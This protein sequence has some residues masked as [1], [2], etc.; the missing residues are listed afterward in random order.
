[1]KT[2]TLLAALLAGAVLLQPKN[3]SPG[4]KPKPAPKP[5]PKPAPK[6]PA[7]LLLLGD[8]QSVGPTSP[9]ARLAA[10]LGKAGKKTA[11]LAKG[12]KTAAYFLKGAGLAALVELLNKKPK[13][14]LVF[15]GSNELANIAAFP[16]KEG[17]ISPKR[18]YAQGR[19]HEQLKKLLVKYG[20]KVLF[21]G[22]P[23]FGEKVKSESGGRPLND[24]APDFV[25]YLKTVYGPAE[26]LDARPLTPPH[27]GVHFF[28]KGEAEAFAA[29]LA[30]AVLVKLSEQIG[31]S[32]F[33]NKTRAPGGIEVFKNP[34]HRQ[35]RKME[36]Q[37]LGVLITSKSAWVWVI[38]KK[39]FAGRT[40]VE[41]LAQAWGDIILPIF[42][43]DT[44]GPNWAYGMA[45]VKMHR[46]GYDPVTKTTVLD[47]APT[48]TF[49]K[50]QHNRIT[51]GHEI[52]IHT[53]PYFRSFF[54][55]I[56]PSVE[57]QSDFLIRR[58]NDL[59]EEAIDKGKAV[60]VLSYRGAPQF[61]MEEA[62]YQ[63][64]AKDIAAIM[65]AGGSLSWPSWLG[66][67]L[68]VAV[69]VAAFIVGP[70]A[71]AG[72]A[73]RGMMTQTQI[74]LSAGVATE[75]VVLASEGQVVKTVSLAA[76]R[77]AGPS[78]EQ[79]LTAAEFNAMKT[80]YIDSLVKNLSSKGFD[81]VDDVVSVVVK[82]A[83]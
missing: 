79:A 39:S 77:A 13:A 63:Q 54:V 22:P 12:G 31:Q 60:E 58:I 26:L 1:M 51:T 30:P 19:A 82:V 57:D 73:L 78:V 21:V 33:S 59:A 15:L 16:N 76:L 61:D 47:D 62:V 48:F 37:R 65:A 3:S 20:V 75:V 32:W 2:S 6:G 27:T 36:G 9:G 50:Y 56:A 40:I 83:R 11:V 14:V 68:I 74:E 49:W 18:V 80:A 64:A 70:E 29:E 24:A 45:T 44:S 71:L 72:M 38:P 17:N 55:D 43:D 42:R 10:L 5:Q 23:G 35:L 67:G 52:D 25:D 53:H 46:P 7:E 34:S 8:S 81:V 66:I 69:G 41:V 4:R 28:G